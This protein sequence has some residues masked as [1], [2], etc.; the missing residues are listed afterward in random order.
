MPSAEPAPRKRR[1]NGEASEQKILDAA[2]AIAAERGYEGTSIGRVSER[3]GLPA[4]SIYWHFKDKDALIAAVIER[5]FTT[6]L[7]N[8]GGLEP[9]DDGAS[10]DEQLS[11]M[12]RRTAAAFRDSSDFLRLGL[13]LT[14]ERRAEEP[15]ARRRFLDVR[16]EAL[17]RTIA[18]FGQLFPELDDAALKQLGAFAM[19]AAD[20]IIIATE[21]DGDDG[22]AAF[23]LLGVAIRAAAKHFAD[24]H[25]R[26]SIRTTS[27]GRGRLA[28]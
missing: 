16:A 14:L 27:G 11:A 10:V 9:D 24:N 28:R 26:S 21:V 22:V 7:A 23:E 2:T 3:S 17:S 20:G 19:A 5:S 1:V 12:M 15:T 25:S 13:M 4:S 8:V 18:S 6:W